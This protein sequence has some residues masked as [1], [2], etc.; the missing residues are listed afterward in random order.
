MKE[1]MLI[2]VLAL[3]T[4]RGLRRQVPLGRAEGLFVKQA[5]EAHQP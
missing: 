4:S 3:S 2:Y 5:G 1:F